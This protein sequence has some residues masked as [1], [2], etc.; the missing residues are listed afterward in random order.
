PAVA[1]DSASTPAA[2]RSLLR[3][4]RTV[5]GLRRI[6]LVVGGPWWLSLEARRLLGG[7]ADALADA[8][9]FTT[10]DAGPCFPDRM[11]ADL[12]AGLHPAARTWADG[13]GM[14]ALQD[15]HRL[16]VAAERYVHV[17]Q[18]EL[19]R[20][21]VEERGLAI[22]VAVAMAQPGD[23]VLVVGK[24][25]MDWQEVGDGDALGETHLARFDDAAECRS[26][27]RALAKMPEEFKDMDRRFMPWIPKFE[28]RPFTM[29]SGSFLSHL[30]Q[31]HDDPAWVARVMQDDV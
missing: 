5:K 18:S 15:P 30:K 11:V 27:M 13:L 26:A 4:V 28:K 19:Q 25:H 3:N 10:C 14:E 7:V 20:Y 8:V 22:R 21:V 31:I 12:V 1:V 6:L 9:F 29:E 23:L 17:L 24:G 2:L 16:P